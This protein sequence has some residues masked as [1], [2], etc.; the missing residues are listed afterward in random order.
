[1]MK[2]LIKQLIHLR[3]S[4]QIRAFRSALSSLDAAPAICHT[5]YLVR[6]FHGPCDSNVPGVHRAGFD[7]DLTRRP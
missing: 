2:T 7:V 4:F 5:R 1:M 6:A 3:A